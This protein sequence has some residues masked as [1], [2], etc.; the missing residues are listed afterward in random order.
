MSA[1]RLGRRF[2][3]NYLSTLGFIGLSWWIITHLSNF[4][5]GILQNQWQFGMVGIDAALTVGE[6][7]AAAADVTRSLSGLG[8]IAEQPSGLTEIPAQELP[9]TQGPNGPAILLPPAQPTAT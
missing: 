3:A 4:H 2:A 6:R 1:A 9:V 8:E 7:S 5:R